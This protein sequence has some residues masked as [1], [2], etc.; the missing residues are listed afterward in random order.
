MTCTSLYRE[1][2]IN[3]PLGASRQQMQHTTDETPQP[4]RSPDL[5]YRKLRWWN[6]PV[7]V[8]RAKRRRIRTFSAVAA[9]VVA[10]TVVATSL[11]N[12]CGLA[13]P[14]PEPTSGISA[15]P[16]F[17]PSLPEIK[18]AAT[19]HWEFDLGQPLSAPPTAAEGIV[20]AVSGTTADSGAISS[21]DVSDGSQEWTVGLDSLAD[22]SPV[23]AGDL[24]FIGTRAGNLLALDR[25]TGATVWTADLESSVVG[26]AIVRAGV[27]YIASTSVFALDAATGDQIWRHEVGGGV[28]RPLSLSRGVISAISSDGNVN[29]INA[30]NGRRRLTFPLWFSTSAAPLVHGTTLVIPGDRAFV[31][32]LDIEQRD[33]PMEKAVRYWWTK[34]WLWDMAPRP[35][36]PRGYLWQ[37]RTLDG[38]TAFA[39][40]SDYN[41]VFIGISQVDGTGAIVALDAASGEASWEVAA[42]S[43]ILA[44]AILA[45]TSVVVGTEQTGVIAVDRQTGVVRW[46]LSVEGGLASAPVVTG[47]GLLLVPTD[48]GLLKAVR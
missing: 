9:L 17:N 22:Y 16:A 48:S 44:P 21:I 31:Q 33:I 47:D 13:L 37:N 36:L 30:G 26:S 25:D 41:S 6:T 28:S 8:L 27:L 20:Y 15:K 43:R 1:T 5:S 24:V 46:Q 19:T 34:L 39:L 32:A 29:L 4:D 3:K 45:G 18:T 11:L 7:G 10:V 40:G 12:Y 23:V 35:P 38:D 14:V 42:E 2:K